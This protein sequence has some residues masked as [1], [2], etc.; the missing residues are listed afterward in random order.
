MNFVPICST[1]PEIPQLRQKKLPW[2]AAEEFILKVLFLNIFFMHIFQHHDCLMYIFSSII[3]ICYYCNV[4]R[5][6][7][8]QSRHDVYF[9]QLNVVLPPDLALTK[10]AAMLLFSQLD[11]LTQLLQN[12]CEI[13]QCLFC[14]PT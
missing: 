2:T 11:L 6:H 1:Y 13:V 3:Q 14:L 4:I 9:R 12:H 10:T 5:L 7:H 8:V